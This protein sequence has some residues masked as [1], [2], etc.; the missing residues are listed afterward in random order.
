MC[1]V[2]LSLP[3]VRTRHILAPRNLPLCLASLAPQTALTNAVEYRRA[4]GG[5]CRY[6]ARTAPSLSFLEQNS[7]LLVVLPVYTKR[8]KRARSSQSERLMHLFKL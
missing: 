4:C 5:R 6:T 7:G 1:S 3:L 2:Y 8:V